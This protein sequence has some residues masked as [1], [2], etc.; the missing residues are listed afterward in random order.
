[1]QRRDELMG[2]A[3]C[4][5]TATRYEREWV[6]FREWW[7]GVGCPSSEAVMDYCVM[8][9]MLGKGWRAGLAAA[10]V[11]WR[12]KVNGWVD[13]V[14]AGEVQ[15]LL[16]GIKRVWG[17]QRR[18]R[19]ARDPF[20][21]QALKAWIDGQGFGGLHPL[22]ERDA[23]LVVLGMRLMRRAAEICNLRVGDLRFADG[24]MWVRIRR[25]KTDQNAVGRE[26]PVDATGT[27]LCPVKW[28]RKAL[29]RRS[30]VDRDA[31]LFVSEKG[32]KM[33]VAAITA[34]VKRMAQR[35]GAQGHFTAH[36]I[37]IGG[38][39]AAMR[40]GMTVEQ[41]RAIGDWQGAAVGRYLH[42]LE[43]AVLGASGR[44]GF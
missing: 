37:R 11:S 5:A 26:I 29:E 30:V 16:K 21:V 33:S 9:E 40:G 44:M 35:T 6:A 39:S 12:A 27:C 31:Y 13:P 7:K 43:T 22:W 41:I 15:A 8:L 32:A 23:A 4:E 3:H 1:V 20:P 14:K 19:V 42:P 36:S 17:N 24:L 38:A 10:A 18:P 28:G 25:S 2:A 34:L